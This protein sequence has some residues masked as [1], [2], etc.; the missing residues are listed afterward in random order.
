MCRVPA[1]RAPHLASSIHDRSRFDLEGPV[2]LL[3]P[4]LLAPGRPGQ[5][6]VMLLVLLQGAALQEPAGADIRIN[7]FL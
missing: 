4:I 5:S 1:H 6:L 3:E 2:Q 7:L